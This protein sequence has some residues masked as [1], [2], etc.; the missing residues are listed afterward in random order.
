M[1]RDGSGIYHRPVGIDAIPNRTIESAKYNANVADVEQDLNTPRPI[2]AG[3]TGANNARDALINLSAEGARQEVVNYASHQFISGSF[4][5]GTGA[6]DSPVAGHYFVGTAVT[7]GDGASAVLHAYD[8]SAGSGLQYSR[9]SDGAGGWGPW[10]GPMFSS[11]IRLVDG[12]V[13]AP[14]Y[15]WVNDTDCGFYR[16]GANNIGLS[17]NVTKVVDYTTNGIGMYTTAAPGAN[18]AGSGYPFVAGFGGLDV[19]G[20]LML[21]PEQRSFYAYGDFASTAYFADNTPTSWGY[22]IGNIGNN[23]FGLLYTTHAFSVTPPF[24]TQ[25]YNSTVWAPNWTYIQNPLSA[26][27]VNPSF[28]NG[29][30]VGDGFNSP[31]ATSLV[32][33]TR[34]LGSINFV[35]SDWAG[36]VAKDL[37]F[38]RQSGVSLQA[39]APAATDIPLAA[40][41]AASQSAALQIWQSSAGTTL[42]SITKDGYYTVTT[43]GMSIGSGIATGLN[44]DGSAVA[45]RTYAGAAK[46]YFQNA[47]G[48][49]TFGD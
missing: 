16:I 9:F 43:V 15:S 30:A 33:N 2:V 6:L 23:Q 12:T 18:A 10:T 7:T 13:S 42:S 36:S 5:S 28:N 21:H 45:L 47:A 38:I 20:V 41:G 44:A 22:A 3:G 17:L 34:G 27:G 8:L 11:P 24:N 37:V 40:K 4:W 32:S 26:A 25:T 39:V 31:G 49:V 1:P 14:A 46:I 19:G 29:V 48:A 35:F